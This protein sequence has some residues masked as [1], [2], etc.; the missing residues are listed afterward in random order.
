MHMTS[1]DHIIRKTYFRGYVA[2]SVYFLRI[3]KHHD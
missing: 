3:G 1:R 2:K